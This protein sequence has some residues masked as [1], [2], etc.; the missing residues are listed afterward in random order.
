MGGV[1]ASAVRSDRV[2]V[3]AGSRK[4]DGKN[5]AYAPHSTVPASKIRKA[6][7]GTIFRI[8]GET[9]DSNGRVTSFFLK[10]RL[11]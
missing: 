9:Y 1:P 4:V 3:Y 2:R 10:C 11:V 7:A 6:G 5:Q 8:E